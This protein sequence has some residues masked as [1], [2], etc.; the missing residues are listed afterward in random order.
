[1][2]IIKKNKNFLFGK[3][4]SNKM[5]KTLIV[6]VKKIVKHKLYGKMIVKFKKYF[7]HNE[8]NIINIGDKIKFF[9]CRPISK[10]K[11][12]LIKCIL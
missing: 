8:K 3:V 9:E 7:V 10:K 12:W 11:H 4:I 1:M 5:D 6:L 2:K